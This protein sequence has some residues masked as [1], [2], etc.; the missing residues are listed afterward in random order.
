MEASWQ[1]L[2][3][4]L[5]MLLKR[6]GF[7]LTAVLTLALGIGA[8][9]AIFSL[10]DTVLLRPLPVTDPTQLVSVSLVKKQG[11]GLGL[12][13]YPNYLDF[14]HQ[15]DVLE[16]LAA[17]RFVPLNFSGLADQAGN[18]ERV[19]GY[20]VSG[21]YFDVLGVKAA[22]GRSFSTEEDRTPHPVVVLS[23]HCWQRR[24]ASDL[25]IVGQSVILNNHPFTV[26]GIAP[27]DFTGTERLFRPEFWVPTMMQSWIDLGVGGLE[28]RGASGWFTVGRLKPGVSTAQAQV[29][30]DA[31]AAQLGREFPQTNEGMTVQLSPPGLV[32]PAARK[33]V[34]GLAGMLVMTVGL[35]LAL[36]C[37]NLAGLLLTRTTERRKEMA[38]RLSLGAGRWRSVRQLL[39]ESLLLAVA[40]GG[41]GILLAVWMVDAMMALKPSLDFLPTIDLKMDHRVL[42]FTLVL[43]LV[44]GLLFGLLPAWQATK[45]D[46]V[47]ALKDEASR[48]GYRR[49]P[50][51]LG[52]IVAQVAL[53]FVLLIA[54]GLMVRSLQ[55]VQ[56][57]GPGF[58]TGHAVVMSL[59]VSLQGYDEARAQEFYRQLIERVESIPGVQSAAVTSFLP[60]SLHYLGVPIY[61]EGQ[62]PARGASISEAMQGSVGLNYFAAMGIPIL[63]GRDFTAQDKKDATPVAIINETFARRFLYGQSSLGKRFRTRSEGPLIEVIGVARDGK[64]FSLSEEPRPFVY[65]PM[66]QSYVGDASNDSTLIARTVGAQGM[67]IAA[68]RREVQQL[69]ANLPVFDVQ[70]LSEHMRLSL[71]PLRV[72]VAG[73]GSFGLLALFLAAIGIYGVMAYEVSQRTREIGIRMALGA[74]ASAVLRLIIGQSLALALSGVGVG[75]AAAFALTRFMGS[76]LFG[77]GATDVMTF[78][79][80]SLLLIVVMLIAC[81]LPARQATKVDPM[82]ALRYE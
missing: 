75:L 74:Q 4:G 8:N 41:L 81:Y 66:L 78:T 50:L 38:I 17:Y 51:R 47:S 30:L 52:L 61:V 44:T 48:S 15:N 5:R 25:S 2:R 59:N 63:A 55:R 60:L 33:P 43:S 62:A 20:I 36:A 68:I 21:N 57:L 71:F 37:V 35:V 56:M 14:R 42:G 24:F 58:E 49:S 80:V 22:A 12:F 79:S 82:V 27:E 28:Q 76:V 23:H 32:I 18:N 46:L 69:D 65:R 67:I 53:S 54:A 70:T 40:G 11:A 9:T 64:Y 7:T 1:D 45:V 6:P 73:V 26:V 13:S 10:V 31:L 77:V 29:A 39:T 72:G 34:L 16:G 3:Y 19:W